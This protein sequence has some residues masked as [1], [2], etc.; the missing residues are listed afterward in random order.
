M[1]LGVINVAP[2]EKHRSGDIGDA[3]FTLLWAILSQ[4]ALIP[5]PLLAE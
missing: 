3:Q 2:T 1:A 4:I 5:A